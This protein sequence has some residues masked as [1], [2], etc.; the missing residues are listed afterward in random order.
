MRASRLLT[1][2]TS[3]KESIFAV[4]HCLPREGSVTRKRQKLRGSVKKVIRSADPTEPEKAQIDIQ[5]A[6]DQNSS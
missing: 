1:L 6:D 4:H 5:E 3:C 2:P